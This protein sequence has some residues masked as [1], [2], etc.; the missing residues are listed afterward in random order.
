MIYSH[1]VLGSSVSAPIKNPLQDVEAARAEL[2]LQ[3]LLGCA[4]LAS[5]LP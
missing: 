4:V 2:R 3:L 1:L 5:A